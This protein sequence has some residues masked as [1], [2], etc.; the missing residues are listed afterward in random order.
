MAYCCGATMVGAIGTLRQGA[1]LVHNVPLLYCPVC[2]QVEVHQAVQEEFELMLDFAH[3]DGAQEINLREHIDEEMIQEWK[4][5]CTSF[6]NGQPEQILR[7]QIDM[8][9]DLMIVA[10]HL[11]DREWEDDLKKRLRVL[12]DRLRKYHKTK[13]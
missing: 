4:E 8:A 3:G 2:H 13:A 6:Q 11:K 9:L 10:K 7:E 5:Y 1:V 12:G